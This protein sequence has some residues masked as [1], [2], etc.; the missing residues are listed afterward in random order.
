[1]I[2]DVIKVYTKCYRHTAALKPPGEGRKKSL[3]V[4]RVGCY[5]RVLIAS[6]GKSNTRTGVKEHGQSTKL[7][8]VK[9]LSYPTWFMYIT[10]FAPYNTLGS[11]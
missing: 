4:C 2:N 3:K 5:S 1:M 7:Q 6:S 11:H 9:C 10:S 8:V